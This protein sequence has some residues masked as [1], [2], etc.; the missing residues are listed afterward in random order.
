MEEWKDVKPQRDPRFYWGFGWGADMNGFA[1][2]G[3]PRGR[4]RTP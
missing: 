4:R 1:H 2:Q 3:D